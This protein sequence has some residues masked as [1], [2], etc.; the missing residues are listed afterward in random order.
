MSAVG[1]GFGVAVGVGFGDS[2]AAG[3]AVE[4]AVGLAVGF[5]VGL[6]VAVAAGVPV[7]AA[8]AS[9]GVVGVGCSVGFSVGFSVGLAVG[10]SVGFSV[11]LAVGFSVGLAVGFS[12]GLAGTLGRAGRDG[13]SM[14]GW[15]AGTEGSSV[16]RA[17]WQPTTTMASRR[18]ARPPPGRPNERRRPWGGADC[19]SSTDGLIANSDRC[20]RSARPRWDDRRSGR[21]HW[22]GLSG[23]RGIPS[24]RPA[25]RRRTRQKIVAK[26]S[27]MLTTVQPRVAAST[28]ARSVPVS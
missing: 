7:G 13:T 12:V 18:A 6:A 9:A 5:S 22:Y 17:P 2:V 14:L 3:L 26:S 19:R 16:G 24:S 21:S 1:V 25:P 27:F 15:T 8:V 28:S 10:F 4:V 20:A 11:G 23:S